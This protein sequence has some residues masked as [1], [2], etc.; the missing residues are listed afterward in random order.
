MKTYVLI[1][2][3]DDAGISLHLRHEPKYAEQPSS[4]QQ[5]AIQA[6]NVYLNRSQSPHVEPTQA[7]TAAE[8]S[9]WPIMTSVVAGLVT[10]RRQGDRLRHAG[11]G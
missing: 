3:N 7:P 8:Q 10:S 6:L 11:D 5:M 1:A 4:A 9:R 2:L